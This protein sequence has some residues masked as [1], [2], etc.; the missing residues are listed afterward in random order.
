MTCYEDPLLQN[1]AADSHISEAKRRLKQFTHYQN[2]CQLLVSDGGATYCRSF[3][4]LLWLNYE[5]ELLFMLKYSLL[6]FNPSW[7]DRYI[8]HVNVS[9]S[10]LQYCTQNKHHCQWQWQALTCCIIIRQHGE[11]SWL[12]LKKPNITS[13]ALQR[14]HEMLVG[15]NWGQREG[16]SS[17]RN[18]MQKTGG[19]ESSLAS[20]IF[21]LHRSSCRLISPISPPW[22]GQLT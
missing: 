8:S 15:R 10:A 18:S 3:D 17:S 2:T 7:T 11:C 13:T 1:R 22:A 19:Q 16:Q 20:Q 9:S 6:A 12:L 5:S 4:S 14:R 21:S